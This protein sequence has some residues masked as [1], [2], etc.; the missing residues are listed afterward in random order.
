VELID[1]LLDRPEFV[2]L[3]T[4]KVERRAGTIRG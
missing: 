1:Q 2:D 4:L 3:W